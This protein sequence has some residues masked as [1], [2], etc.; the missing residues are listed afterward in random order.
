MARLI[1]EK[2]TFDDPVCSAEEFQEIVDKQVV[3]PSDAKNF[4]IYM[5]RNDVRDIHQ[6]F[7]AMFEK[8]TRLNDCVSWE[9]LSQGILR[10]GFQQGFNLC[11][12]NATRYA[13]YDMFLHVLY[14]YF[15]YWRFDSEAPLVLTELYTLA[16]S[17]PD[18]YV[19]YFL[20]RLE[21]ILPDLDDG[22]P[23]PDGWLLNPEAGARGPEGTVPRPKALAQWFGEEDEDGGN[24]FVEALEV[25]VESSKLP[26]TKRCR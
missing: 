17:N 23:N 10:L 2:F 5:H 20:K 12:Q 6:M 14:A 21:P 26:F 15:R 16:E 19:L 8:A 3:T 18:G 11:L 1:T 25:I 13:N 7:D 24:P 22:L 9:I 4:V